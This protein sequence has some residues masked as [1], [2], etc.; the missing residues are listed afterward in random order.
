MSDTILPLVGPEALSPEWH[1]L[2][3]FEAG[4]QPVS[5]VFGATDA[6]ACCGMSPF[7]TPLDV[8]VH[9]SYGLDVEENAAMRRGKRFEGPILDEYEEVRKVKLKRGLPI[10]FHG[11][12][13]WMGATPDGIA[14]TPEAA[15]TTMIFG[16]WLHGVDAKSSTYRRLD[17]DGDDPLKFGVAG[18][19]QMPVDYL[20]QGQQQCGVLNL[21]FIE[22][23]V[24]FSRDHVP[25]YRV[26]R[27][28]ELI[29]CIVKAE[30]EMFERLVNNDP[31]EP[32]WSHENTREL[33]GILFKHQR[34]VVK[35][36]DEEDLERW[37]SV[38]RKSD[39]MKDLKEEID[40]DKNHL[41]YKL[42]GA[43]FGRFP[44]G[45]AQLKKIIV[46]D[47]LWSQKDVDDARAAIGTVK[48]KGHI[49]LQQVKAQEDS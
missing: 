8:F 12:Y 27:N 41:L 29:E 49:R 21:P 23:P 25:I 43:T 11:K 4:R 28:D 38:Q 42:E 22:F 10:F 34:D 35:E 37:L 40:A 44:G 5:V 45:D 46:K 20:M 3:K 15:A 2:R 31:P 14:V 48:R 36:L 47:A 6:A 39:Q 7:K 26:E 18:T 32:N 30:R 13:K 33:I 24:M 19:D 17:K 1:A 9:K 16:G